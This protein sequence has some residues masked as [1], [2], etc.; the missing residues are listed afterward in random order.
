[1]PTTAT[2]TMPLI[3]ALNRRD[4]QSWISQVSPDLRCDYPGAPGLDAPAARA[5]CESYLRAFSDL[6]FEVSSQIED[7][8]TQVA[9]WEA[10]GTHDGPLPTPTGDLPATGK[11]GKVRGV[12][13]SGTVLLEPDQLEPDRAAAAARPGVGTRLDREGAGS[14]R[15]PRPSTEASA[16]ARRG[17]WTAGR[18]TL[19]I[20]PSVPTSHPE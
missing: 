16:T 20:R 2:R 18:S 11:R 15:S 13:V 5:Y 7:G 4:F 19:R 9:V 10:T 1:M 8:D 3:D 12:G 14:C 6:H 17:Y